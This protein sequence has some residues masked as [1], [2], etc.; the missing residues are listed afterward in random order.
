MLRSK[1]D[2]KP[3]AYGDRP[4]IDVWQLKRAYSTP[5]GDFLALKGVDLQVERGEF[6]AVIGKSG[7][8]KSTFI[9]ILSGIDRATSGEVMIGG[10]PVHTLNEVQMAE[11]RG[12]NLGIVFQFFQL[13][14]T[15][16]LVENIILAMDL[17]G[18]YGRR[19]RRERA[20]HLLEMVDMTDHARKLPSAVSGGQQQRVAIARALANDPPLIIADEPTGNLDSR[21]A[22]DIFRMFE[23]LVANGKT[24]LMVTHDDDLARRVDR[25]VMIS[26]GEVVNEYLVQALSVLGPDQLAEVTRKVEPVVFEPRETVIQQGTVGDKFYIIVDGDADVFIERPGGTQN[27]ISRLGK[28]Q[29]FGEMALIGNGVRT[30]TVRATPDSQLTAVVL[31]VNT[32]NSIV[33]ES[34]ALREEL[35]HIVDRRSTENQLQNIVALNPDELREFTMELKIQSYNPG[36]TIIRQGDIGN[37]FYIVIEGS[38]DVVHSQPSG[39]EILLNQL[40]GGQYFGEMALMGNRRRNATVRVSQNE[41]AKVVELSRDDFGHLIGTSGVLKQQMERIADERQTEL[42]GLTENSEGNSSD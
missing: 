20:M 27:Y 21:T 18:M 11:W 38:V 33:S 1:G 24:I 4:F 14:P 28:G 10:I 31:D 9:N 34:Q 19:E 23:E 8:G 36:A 41:P 40:H 12:Q 16:T 25:T 22:E 13:L 35:S 39:K 26:D 2:Q 29:Y 42:E 6:V 37:T 5:A 30:A 17:N 32:F 7:S 15:L 3:Y